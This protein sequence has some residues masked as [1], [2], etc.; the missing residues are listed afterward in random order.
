MNLEYNDTTLDTLESRRML[1]TGKYIIPKTNIRIFSYK[2][3]AIK[4][5]GY[6]MIWC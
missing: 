2:L 6:I 5:E 1:E 3:L 4:V